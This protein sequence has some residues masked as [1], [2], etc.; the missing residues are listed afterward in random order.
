M[1]PLNEDQFV[2]GPAF[3]AKPNSQGT[4]FRPARK[5]AGRSPE[6]RLP[7]G[8]TPGRRQAVG[9][10]LNL[11]YAASHKEAS[12]RLINAVARST[13]P[14]QHLEGLAAVIPQ[15]PASRTGGTYYQ[16]PSEGSLVRGPSIHTN[17]KRSDNIDRTIIH[18]LGHHVNLHHGVDKD[19]YDESSSNVRPSHANRGHRE[20]FADKYADI[21]ARK[22]GY[23]RRPDTEEPEYAPHRGWED[24]YGLGA[25][26][27]RVN[28][29]TAYGR[30]RLGT[31][32]ADDYQSLIS[33]RQFGKQKGGPDD[34]GP[35]KRNRMRHEE[36]KELRAGNQQMFAAEYFDS[37]G[38]TTLAGMHYYGDPSPTGDH[39]MPGLKSNWMKE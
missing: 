18:E 22:P 9:E 36:I 8:F 33:D 39:R 24:Q 38:I 12:S 23:K 35:Y 19:P 28:F 16:Y 26:G 13:V 37:A 10:A 5:G 30:A 21:H 15:S 1:A 3:K 34:F 4:L 7:R 2:Y 14:L 27:G 11:S 29:D 32:T 25:P 20:G 17:D 31:Q 6:S